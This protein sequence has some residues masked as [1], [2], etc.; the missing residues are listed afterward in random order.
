M[1]EILSLCTKCIFAIGFERNPI[2]PIYLKDGSRLY[3]TEIEYDNIM[4]NLI[5]KYTN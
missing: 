3:D 2:D 4:A 1:K 5:N